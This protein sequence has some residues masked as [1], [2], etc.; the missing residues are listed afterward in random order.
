VTNREGEAELRFT[1][2]G[3]LTTWEVDAVASTLDG[4]I[5][6]ASTRF[7]AYQPFFLVHDPPRML[8]E[9]DEIALPVTAHNYLDRDETA[10]IA[11][12]PETWLRLLDNAER[13]ATIASGEIRRETFRF[14]AIAPVENGVQRVSAVGSRASDAVEKPVSVRPDGQEQS[15]TAT[16]I[17]RGPS[18]F[19]LTIPTGALPNSILGELRIYPDLISQLTD[20]VEGIF[21]RPGGCA[22]QTI[23]SSYPSLMILQLAE[24]G[25]PRAEKLRGTARRY[26]ETGYAALRTFQTK[27]GGFTYWQGT[28]DPDIAVTAYAIQFLHDAGEFIAVDKEIANRAKAWLLKEQRADGSWAPSR[29][30]PDVADSRAILALTGFVARALTAVGGP[31]TAGLH[32]LE[33]HAPQSN[34]PHA[35]ATLAIAAQNTGRRELLARIVDQLKGLARSEDGLT[36]WVAATPTPFY[37]WGLPARLETTALVARALGALDPTADTNPAIHFLLHN[38]DRYRVWHSSQTTVQVL[39]T[40]IRQ[41]AANPAPSGKNGRIEVLVNGATAGSA[42][43]SQNGGPVSL[44]IAK[45]LHAG[46]NRIEIRGGRG[47]SAATIQTIETHYVPWPAAMPDTANGLRLDIRFDKTGIVLGDTVTC[48]VEAQRTTTAGGGMLLAEIGL[49]PGAEVDRPSLEAAV[50]TPG[51]SLH[52]FEILPDRV[53]FYLWPGGTQTA[54]FQ[55]KLKPRYGLDAQT[56]ASELYDYYNPE[57]RV[58]AKPTHFTVR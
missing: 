32:Y 22:E 8:T 52:R 50:R 20:A 58:V 57:A 48:T 26:L 47:M 44:N 16:R 45:L 17:F 31:A 19:D 10:R 51:T 15:Q 29:M 38:R 27:D 21:Q 30:P 34:D 46:D 54:R 36:Y 39:D 6:A 56:A 1:L 42:T 53:V 11:M 35:L 4:R 13:T 37:G 14:K 9:G 12:K 24:K 23:S 28:S 7:L 25:D 41:V 55:F 18:T 43:L 5:A 40:L 33:D 3:N 2:S 49:P